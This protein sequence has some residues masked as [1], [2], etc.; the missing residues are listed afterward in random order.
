MIW[1]GCGGCCDPARAHTNGKH[2]CKWDEAVGS[3][4]GLDFLTCREAHGLA[5][6][7]ELGERVLFALR[8]AQEGGEEAA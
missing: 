6:F 2:V 1:R 3:N 4:L 7:F 8:E 5:V